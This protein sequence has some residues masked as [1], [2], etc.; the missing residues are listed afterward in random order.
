VANPAVAVLGGTGFLGTAVCGELLRRELPYATV[1]RRPL[2]EDTHRRADIQDAGALREALRGA[3]VVVNLVAASPLLPKGRWG[4]YY[5]FHV[6]GVRRLLAICEDIGVSSLIHVGA[7]GVSRDSHAPYAQTKALAE[8]LVDDAPID[9]AV[10]SP[11]ILFGTGSE[12]VA[13][14]R[15]VAVLPVA[16]VPRISALFQP[17][18]VG[19]MAGLIADA[20]AAALGPSGMETGHWEVAG[21]DTLSGTEFAERYLRHRGVRCI[22]IPESAVSL[23]IRGAAAL[24]LPGFPVG[25]PTML[26]M[27]NTLTGRFPAIRT[28]RRYEE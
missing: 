3:E 20:A 5:R 15:R 4:R 9:S 17:V 18:Y 19:D 16:P 23:A 26:E 1:S 8:D 24:H 27:P 2:P 25:L 6:Q 28:R 11:S 13:V 21:P 12:L 10:F 22:H 7:L 14:L